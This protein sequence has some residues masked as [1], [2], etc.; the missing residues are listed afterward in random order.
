MLVIRT[1]KLNDNLLETIKLFF[2]NNNM[3]ISINGSVLDYESFQYQIIDI[4]YINVN[5][6]EYIITNEFILNLLD[7]IH[8]PFPNDYDKNNHLEIITKFIYDN[9]TEFVYDRN[10]TEKFIKDYTNGMKRVVENKKYDSLLY[11]N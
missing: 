10:D 11:D 9:I 6:D 8:E 1:Y 2:S 4:K 5:T 7:T 3:T